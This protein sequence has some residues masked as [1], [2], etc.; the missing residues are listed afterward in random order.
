MTKLIDS[1]CGVS[2]RT[3][4]AILDSMPS[5]NLSSASEIK[6]IIKGEFRRSPREA[7]EAAYSA[8][9]GRDYSEDESQYIRRIDEFDVGAFGKDWPIDDEYN[10]ALVY[11]PDN[12]KLA[13]IQDTLNDGPESLVIVPEE[14]AKMSGVEYS[15]VKPGFY[16]V[17]SLS[18]KLDKV[19]ES[20]DEVKK[21]VDS[22]QDSDDFDE[23][24]EDVSSDDMLAILWEVIR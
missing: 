10:P 16:F 17:D 24:Y 19:G 18:L 5:L 9:Y 2:C 20:V 13:V 23:Y 4:H 11:V 8:A 1:L 22:L 15:P 21:W 6:S 14:L 12:G 7:M 3:G